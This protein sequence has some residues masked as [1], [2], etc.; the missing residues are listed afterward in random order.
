M[1]KI[2]R[3]Y[4][5]LP[6]ERGAGKEQNRGREVKKYKLLYVKYEKYTIMSKNI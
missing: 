6:V 2:Q 5:Q 3:T 4:L 1:N